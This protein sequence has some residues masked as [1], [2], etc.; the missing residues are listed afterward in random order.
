VYLQVRLGKDQGNEEPE[1]GRDC[2][3]SRHDQSGRFWP[4]RTQLIPHSVAPHIALSNACILLV[5]TAE[6]QLRDMKRRRHC[7]AQPQI[8]V[9]EA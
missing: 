3:G 6:N 9:A 2:H 8:K 7:I 5:G 4:A 1:Q